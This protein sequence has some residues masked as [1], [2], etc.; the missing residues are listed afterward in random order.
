MGIY[1]NKLV[2]LTAGT[3]LAV[4]A[5]SASAEEFSKNAAF[6]TDYVWR[7]LSQTDNRAALQAGADYSN[8]NAYASVWVSNVEDGNNAE[9]MPV[10]M[11]VSFG[12]NNQFDK[13]NLDTSITTYNYLHDQGTDLTEFRVA[14]TPVKG[15]EIALNREIKLK[16]WYPEV[17]FEKFLPHRLYLDLSAG[18]WSFDGA[19]TAVTFR[20]ELA[21]DFPEFHHVDL[22]AALT[23]IS[24][25]TVTVNDTQE[26]ADT[27]LLVG[28]RKRF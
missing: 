10:E 5:I 1:M 17:S 19:D 9:G 6:V 23:Y 28:V 4:T 14:T 21:R 27:L 15:L 16:Y 2:T 8:G 12:Y 7:G 24:D 11:D 13:F 18:L 25:D 22:F 3:V 20:G 26:D